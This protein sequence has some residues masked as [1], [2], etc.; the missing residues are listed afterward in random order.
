MKTCFIAQIIFITSF[1]NPGITQEL[2]ITNKSNGQNVKNETSKSDRSNDDNSD[3]NLNSTDSL[4]DNYQMLLEEYYKLPDIKDIN[5][6]RT[7]D[8]KTYE[9]TKNGIKMCDGSSTIIIT[10]EN[11]NIPEDNITALALDKDNHLWIGTL[12]SGI[13]IG[14]GGCIKPYKIKPIK[15]RGLNIYSI[16]T[17]EKGRVWVEYK[18]GEIECFRDGKSIAYFPKK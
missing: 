12:N 2:K 13:V 9:G 15:T 3:H 11:S 5:F 18:N 16:S 6:I 7:S 10:T 4:S 14:V 17:D 1:V 8:G